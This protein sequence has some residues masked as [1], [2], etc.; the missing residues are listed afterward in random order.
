MRFLSLRDVS[1]REDV[2]ES[3]DALKS[4]VRRGTFPPHDAEVGLGDHQRKTLGWSRDTIDEWL[5]TR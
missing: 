4:M 2:K 3:L 1:D 5:E